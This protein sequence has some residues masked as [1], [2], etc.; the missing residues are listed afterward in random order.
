MLLSAHSAVFLGILLFSVTVQGV[1][2]GIVHNCEDYYIEV[3]IPRTL[4]TEPLKIVGE[5]GYAFK[6]RKIA[7]HCGYTLT[8]GQDDMLVFRA[9]YYACFIKKE[10][11][12]YSLELKVGSIRVP[13]ICELGHDLLTNYTTWVS[14]NS[15]RAPGSKIVISTTRNI[16]TTNQ[17]N[18][19]IS[20]DPS[21]NLQCGEPEVSEAECVRMGCA[22]DLVKDGSSCFYKYTGCS[23]DGHFVIVVNRNYT[24]PPLSLSTLHVSSGQGVQCQAR[25]MTLDLAVFHFPVNQCG[26]KKLTLKDRIIYQVEV[27]AKREILL[28][29]N[30]SITLDSNFRFW[31]SCSYKAS[32]DVAMKSF[33]NP[34]TFLEPISEK[35]TVQLQLN[36][37]RDRSYTSWFNTAEFPLTRFLQEPLLFEVRLVHH[38]DPN[39]E[40]VL[41]SCWVTSDPNPAYEVWWP[42]LENSCPVLGENYLPLLHEVHMAQKV[43]FPSHHKRLEMKMFAFVN[44][45]SGIPLNQQ[46]FFHCRAMLCSSIRGNQCSKN[47][48]HNSYE[49]YT[50]RMIK[51]SHISSVLV[52]SQGAVLLVQQEDSL[53]VHKTSSS[54][55]WRGLLLQTSAVL[56][57]VVGI[58][59]TLLVVKKFV[60]KFC[61]RLIV[62]TPQLYS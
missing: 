27:V 57:F 16:E 53:S 19:S 41:D 32:G 60:Q 56:F 43:K 2:W 13:V 7:R 45:T 61:S 24:K 14:L 22:Y 58:V 21:F 33:V 51:R 1:R 17:T 44:H 28:S 25:R 55:Q 52:S 62:Q 40:L 29:S 47:C 30:F 5:H 15:S 38:E 34:M 4:V 36:F 26:S 11:G 3:H 6:V 42:L 59:G 31:L 8:S 20:R 37:A 49:S 50:H 48:S 46:L 54:L 18:Y 23:A 35:G 10:Q 39:V 12:F 9:T